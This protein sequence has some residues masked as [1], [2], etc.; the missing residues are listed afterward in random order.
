MPDLPQDLVA[1]GYGLGFAPKKHFRTSLPP[2]T[3]TYIS[4][5]SHGRRGKQLKG[6]GIFSI[7]FSI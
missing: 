7:P 3:V 4:E 5:C 2:H 6:A 1:Y